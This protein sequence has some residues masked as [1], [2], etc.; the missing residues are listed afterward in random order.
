MWSRIEKGNDSEQSSKEDRKNPELT[1]DEWCEIH[2]NLQI[3]FSTTSDL[4]KGI[5]RGIVE[6]PSGH[7]GLLH[8]A[9]DIVKP[10]RKE[11]ETDSDYE[12]RVK[13]HRMTRICEK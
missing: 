11:G 2:K 4:A 12:L 13:G 9:K 8:F 5:S 10:P 6:A 3:L 7:I 1:K